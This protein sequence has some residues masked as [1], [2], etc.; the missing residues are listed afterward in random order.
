MNVQTS[1]TAYRRHPYFTT[2]KDESRESFIEEVARL[3]SE[4]SPRKQRHGVRV[5]ANGSIQHYVIQA[6]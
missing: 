2:H 5:L 4:L 3:A 6:I 1:S